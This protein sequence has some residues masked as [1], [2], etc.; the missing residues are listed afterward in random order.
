MRTLLLAAILVAVGGYFGSKLYIQHKVATDLDAMLTQIRPFVDVT[1]ENVTASM[2]GE[3]SVGGVRVRSTQFD[4]PLTI[5]AVTVETP[6]FGFLLGFDSEDLEI[7]ERFGI[8]VTGFRAAID[9]DFLLKIDELGRAEAGGV[10]RAPADMC[11]SGNGLSPAALRSVG[12]RELVMNLRFAFRR[13]GDKLD[14][15]FAAH[16]EDMYD[17]DFAVKLAGVTDPMELAQGA[18]PVLIEG[19][20]DYVDR[21]MHARVMKHCTEVRGVPADRV[22]AAQ[23]LELQTIARDSGME[24]D[25]LILDPYTEFITG[26]QRFTV[27]A[28]PI[29][30]VDLTQLNLYK[31][32]DVPH[33]LNLMAEAH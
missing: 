10:A 3:L 18:R 4:D 1:Y 20:M 2:N 12:Y 11:T 5:D 22:V 31:P 9:A 33:L 28:K 21:S 13:D 16:S 25:K 30:P 32:S 15:D 23:L 29:R 7:P 14:V 24:L 27:T 26:K 17:L 19:R 6:G 8:A